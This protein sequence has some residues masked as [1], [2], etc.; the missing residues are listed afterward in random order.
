MFVFL[1]SRKSGFI[2]SC[3]SFEDLP[4]NKIL[5]SLVDWCKFCIRL[6]S[7]K[8]PPSPYSKAPLKKIMI[9]IQLV[10]MPMIFHFT[11][12]HLSNKMVDE[13]TS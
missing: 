8:I 1:V 4:A 6:R 9:Q 7:L 5:W 12:L 2:K 11:E 3:S 10:G 13:F